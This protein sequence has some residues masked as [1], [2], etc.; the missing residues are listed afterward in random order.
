MRSRGQRFDEVVLDCFERLCERPK[1]RAVAVELAVEDVPPS[2]PAPWEDQIALA[3]AFPADKSL[4]ARIVVYRRPIETRAR[5]EE[6]L[7]DLVDVVLAENL[8]GLLGINPD[9]LTDD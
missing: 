9:D 4:P 5:G 6:D 8:A 1:L 3:R 7:V 2:D